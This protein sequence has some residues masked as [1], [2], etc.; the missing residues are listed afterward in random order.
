MTIFNYF[1]EVSLTVSVEGLHE[2]CIRSSGELLAAKAFTNHLVVT[3]DDGQLAAQARGEEAAIALGQLHE[4]CVLL[5][6]H[7]QQIANDGEAPRAGGKFAELAIIAKQPLQQTDQGQEAEE[8]QQQVL[9]VLLLLH[10][11]LA[12]RELNQVRVGQ[13]V[14][15]I[16]LALALFLSLSLSCSPSLSLSVSE[17]RSVWGGF[18]SIGNWLTGFACLTLPRTQDIGCCLRVCVSVRVCACRCVSVRVSFSVAAALL[19]HLLS[20]LLLIAAAH[21]EKKLFVFFFFFDLQLI[22]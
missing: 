13:H 21:Y 5:V 9:R 15:A 7:E 4:A 6:A 11:Q 17:C 3:H 14:V 12:E 2:R 22:F 8:H 19:S 20:L 1:L 18:S 10:L 16:S